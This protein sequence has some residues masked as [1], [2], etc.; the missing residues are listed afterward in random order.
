[1]TTRLIARPAL[2][3]KLTI[4]LDRGALFL[5][6]PA[7]C[8]KTVALEAAVE[9]RTSAIARVRCSKADG[10]AGRLLDHLVDALCEAVPGSADALRE[11]LATAVGPVSTSDAAAELVTELERLLIDPLIVVLDDAEHVAVDDSAAAIVGALV[12]SESDALRVALASRRPL[13]LRLAKLE[14]TGRLTVVGESDLAFSPDECEEL[15]RRSG[16][17]DPTDAEVREAM[18][19]TEGWPLGLALRLRGHRAVATSE[20]NHSISAFLTE[21]VL[22]DLDPDLRRQLLCSSIA[23]ELT[24]PICEAIGLDPAFVDVALGRNLFLRPIDRGGGEHSRYAYH[25]LFREFL[26]ERLELELDENELADLHATIARAISDDRP[27]EAVE[28]WLA[29]GREKEAIRLVGRHSQP[30]VRGSTDIVREWIGRLSPEGRSEPVIRLLEG[31][32]AMGDGKPEEAV[33]LLGEAAAEWERRG[34]QAMW[35]ARF[36]VALTMIVLGRFSE[37]PALTEGFEDESA[38]GSIAAPMVGL[39][40]GLALGGAGDSEAG[41]DLIDRALAH[42]IGHVLSPY[43]DLFTAYFIERPAGHLD[44]A[45]ER[46]ELANAR[47]EHLDPMRWM[48]YTL[49]YLA[50]VLEARGQADAAIEQLE[51]SRE[52]THRYGLGA[53]PA[54]IASAIK[55]GLDARA[56]RAAEARVEIARASPLGSNWHAHELELARAELARQAGDRRAALAAAERAHDLARS[57]FLLERLRAAVLL[58][59]LLTD[60]G[61]AGRAREVVDEALTACLGNVDTARLHALRAWLRELGGESGADREMGEAWRQTGEGA[62]HLVRSDW[63]RIE[64]LV[65]KAVESGEIAPANVVEAISDA[66]PA[67][68]AEFDLL[69][70]T[71]DRVRL[72]AAGAVA[73]SGH[74][75]AAARL[76][77]MAKADDDE[78]VR[79]VAS[80]ALERLRSH[81][82]GLA[83]SLFG[84]F[85]VRRGGRPV[86]DEEW[87]RRAAPRLIKFLLLNREGFVP[88]DLLFE[89]FWPNRSEDAARRSLQVAVS[90]A[91]TALEPPGVSQSVVEVRER[92]YRLALRQADAVD[93]ELYEQA[94][95]AALADRGPDRLPALQAAASLWDGD[96][97]PEDRYEPWATIWR[98]RLI[99]LHSDLLGALTELLLATGDPFAATAW[100]RRLIDLDPLNEAAHRR[101]IVSFAR[102]GRRGHALRQFLDCRRELVDGLGVEPAAETVDLHRAVLAGESV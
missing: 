58:A 57:G 83:F 10:D 59:P 70:H 20:A 61:A 28:H 7:G 78:R 65:W 37:V 54:A 85:T 62:W 93:T 33:E 96:P 14:V 89:A 21:E 23:A 34:N 67:G 32:I 52:Y 41:K 87:Q 53:Y 44:A 84:R 24:S 51:R 8:G 30:L 100:A 92:A 64:P 63:A 79:V 77:E 11:T 97:L 27:L 56:G 4:A 50:G 74:P 102:S 42:P 26:L 35:V 101:L 22:D 72:A 68:D 86:A 6:A 76:A 69:A 2:T 25:P 48:P 29:A 73:A 18:E 66:F 19:L 98:E 94:A 12:T 95:R 5:I 39:M 40:A 81:P 80:D 49:L 1:M 13:P 45:L 90:A 43:G 60:L 46:A 17:S 9:S 82:P 3:R 36:S 16:R 75:G 99:D 88:E 31:Q 15:L 55:A 38:A 71:D 47:L 91:R